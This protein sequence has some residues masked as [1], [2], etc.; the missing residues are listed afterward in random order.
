MKILIVRF[1][2]IGDIVLTTPVI[3]ALHQQLGAEVHFLTKK[4][5]R[6]ILDSN[7]YLSKVYSFERKL[8]ELLPALQAE[9]YDFICDLH[10]NLRS[11]LLKLAL[12]R[13]TR[14]FDKLNLAKWLLVRWKI[15]RLPPVHIVD[16]YLASVA[17]LGV[18]NDGKGLDYFIPSAQEVDLQ[19]LPGLENLPEMARE[20]V[21]MGQFIAYV[22]GAAH[23]TKRMPAEQIALVCRQI[24]QPI[25]L[26]G[27]PDDREAGARI[28]AEA[29]AHTL[30]L[31]GKL[32]LHQS[33][34]VL[35]QCKRVISHDTGLMHMAAAL[36]KPITAVWGN[37]VPDFGMYP[38]YPADDEGGYI[39]VEAPDLPCRPCSKIGYG[40]CPQ[41]H[42]RCM[43][44]IAPEKIVQTL[45]PPI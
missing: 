39:N 37:T 36:R 30:D 8:G 22:I 17:H 16:R 42:F 3:R 13:P 24:K 5:F 18:K 43:R 11:I 21:A 33:A 40:Q 23:A 44:D 14:A 19:A 6:G 27:G 34:S 35:R 28:A 7:P 20:Q 38:Y 15:N 31:C 9:R 10:H 1:S 29:G 26:L 32:N 2:S 25:L 4:N 45:A 41:G 12:R